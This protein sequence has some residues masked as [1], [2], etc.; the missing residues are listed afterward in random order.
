MEKLCRLLEISRSG[1]YA[2]LTR[3]QSQRAQ[4]NQA[5]TRELVY[6]HEKYPALGLDS[7]YHM[8][9]ANNSCSRGRVH[10]LMKAAGIHSMRKKAYKTTTNSRHSHPIAPNLLKRQFSFA[11]PN[12][13]WVGDITYIPTG[14]GWLY[15]AAAKDLCTKKVV[16]YAFSSRI[17]T[18]LTLSA[19]DMAVRRE[20][21]S[22]GLIFH[23]D[24]GIQYAAEA[25]RRRLAALGIRQSMSRNFGRRRHPQLRHLGTV[26]RTFQSGRNEG[27]RYSERLRVRRKLLRRAS[28]PHEH[29]Y[30]P[31]DGAD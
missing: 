29:R 22:P 4:R 30:E 6:L 13:A 25:F 16:G 2:W 15:L 28:W 7:L 23:S 24:R 10:R 17:D 27:Q 20:R 3:R 9:K 12:Q 19:L 5:L 14:E 21:P 1:Y 31:H 8:L 18:Q 26:L 11:Q